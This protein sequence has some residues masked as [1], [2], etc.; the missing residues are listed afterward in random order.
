[1]NGTWS[2]AYPLYQV[3]GSVER[4]NAIDATVAQLSMI[5]KA[6]T[7]HYNSTDGMY[8]NYVLS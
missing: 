4:P 8:E 7:A 5:D 6:F 1:M 2:L 3:R